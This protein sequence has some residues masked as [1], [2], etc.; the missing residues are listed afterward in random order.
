MSNSNIKFESFFVI[1]LVFLLPFLISCGHPADKNEQIGYTIKNIDLQN[2]KIMDYGNVMAAENQNSTGRSSINN[3]NKNETCGEK[4]IQVNYSSGL[5]SPRVYAGILEP[6]SFLIT[7]FDPLK[8]DIQ[9]FLDENNISASIYI[10]NLRNGVN[11]GIHQ[12]MGYFPASLNKLPVAVLIMQEIED[13]EISLNSTLPVMDY[14]RTDASGTLYLTPENKLTVRVLLEKMIQESDNTA[15]SILYDHVNKKELSRLLDYYN[16][17][18]NVDYPYRR[19]EYVNQTDQVTA[20]S[21]YNFFSSLYLSTVLEPQD[22]EYILSLL[23]NTKFDIK[24]LADLPDE[25]IVSQK[26][27]EY[28]VDHTKLFHDCGIIY[29][30]VSRIFYCIMTNNV[31]VQDAPR[32]I[33]HIVNYIYNYVINTRAELDK[34]K[35][36]TQKN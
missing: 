16:I 36:N 4:L 1:A 2:K 24:K 20:I 29:I 9:S 25:V 8:L 11:F 31:E 27:G 21:L 23:S 19:L 33:G 34:Y 7:N 18:I 30:G 32:F 10:E 6:R 3:E 28:Y 35:N 17:K 22:S 26:Y 13:G 12:S 14:E 15:F 5:L